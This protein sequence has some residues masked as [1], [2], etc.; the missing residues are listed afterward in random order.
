[1]PMD[2]DVHAALAAITAASAS[3]HHA[4]HDRDRDYGEGGGVG[5]GVGAAAEAVS[6][7]ANG[8]P[9]PTALH[10]FTVGQEMLSRLANVPAGASACRNQVMP[11]SVV[12]RIELSVS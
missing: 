10:A 5:V 11:P 12:R 6:S 8:P 3:R 2:C 9:W 7:G 4:R 1:M